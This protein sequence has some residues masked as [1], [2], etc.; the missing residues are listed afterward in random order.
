M[1]TAPMESIR[2]QIAEIDHALATVPVEAIDRTPLLQQERHR[3][4]TMITEIEQS[5]EFRKAQAETKKRA[6]TIPPKIEAFRKQ[7]TK[8]TGQ[9]ENARETL[10]AAMAAIATQRGA[11]DALHVEAYASG[12]VA[13]PRFAQLIGVDEGE[14]QRFH[15]AAAILRIG[16]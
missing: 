10:S 8:L 4:V 5:A 11:Y 14:L 13:V 12:G 16:S 9:I 15:A 1:I 2:A 3:L 7:A 6:A